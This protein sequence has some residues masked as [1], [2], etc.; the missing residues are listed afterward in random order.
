VGTGFVGV[1]VGLADA[2]VGEVIVI[3]V[4]VGSMIFVITTGC[5]FGEHAINTIN[6]KRNETIIFFIISLFNP[7]GLNGINLLSE[8]YCGKLRFSYSKHS[9]YEGYLRLVN[10]LNTFFRK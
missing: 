5:G 7:T 6:T 10:M 8:I 4:C 3:A 1:T 9:D 2:V